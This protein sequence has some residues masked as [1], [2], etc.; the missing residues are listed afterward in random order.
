M[1]QINSAPQGPLTKLQK[2]SEPEHIQN[3]GKMDVYLFE[4]LLFRLIWKYAE[5]FKELKGG[6]ENEHG[7]NSYQFQ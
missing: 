5:K 1:N 2:N 3:D 7:S 4:L 6:N